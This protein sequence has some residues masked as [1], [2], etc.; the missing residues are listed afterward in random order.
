MQPPIVSKQPSRVP[1]PAEESVDDLL[2]SFEKRWL[3]D[4][5]FLD[6][7][8]LNH[9]LGDD[10]TTLCELVRA[11]LDRKYTAGLEVSLAEYF[12]SYPLLRTN[13]EWV[14]DIC[15]EDFRARTTR[16]LST[17]VDRWM[18]FPEV[19]NTSWWQRLAVDSSRHSRLEIGV[20]TNADGAGEPI[21]GQLFGEFRLVGLLGTGA[22][23]QVYLATQPGLASR[24]VALKVVRRVFDEP[25]HLA[26]LQHTGIVPLYSMHRIGSYTAL[27]MPYCGAA[28]LADWV[29]MEESD[30]SRSGQSLV[31]TIRSAERRITQL[32]SNMVAPS[33][34]L[35]TSESS[36]VADEAGAENVLNQLAPLGPSELPLW[37]AR[38]VAAA[39]AH[40]HLR[41]VVHG[42]LKP[43]N[44]L[45]RNDGEPALIDFNLSQSQG[46]LSNAV[47][48][49]TLPYMSPEQL[50][51][52]LGRGV[53]LSTRSDIFSFGVVM[54]QWIEGRM[55]F[56]VPTSTA[57]T[58]LEIAID[59]LRM[60]LPMRSEYVSPGFRA[61]L[62]KC[63][64]F[65]PSE[66]YADATELEEDLDREVNSRPLKFADEPMLQ[67]RCPKW[68][69]RNAI[70]LRYVAA[71][72]A[73][74]MLW[75]AIGV[76]WQWRERSIRL[77]AKQWVETWKSGIGTELDLLAVP[78][79]RSLTEVVHDIDQRASAITDPTAARAALHPWIAKLGVEEVSS[80]KRQLADHLLVSATLAL[81]Q[82]RVRDPDVLAILKRWL[83]NCEQLQA[84]KQ[85]LLLD[86]LG[87][88]LDGFSSDTISKQPQG[89]A[90]AKWMNRLLE[91]DPEKLPSIER[92]LWAW[93][94]NQMGRTEGVVAC[95]ESIEPMDDSVG[96]YWTVLGD[97]RTLLGEYAS[98]RRAY[99]IAMQRTNGAN[100]IR[101]RNA[102]I[103][104]RMGAWLEAEDE[105]GRVLEAE[106]KNANVLADRARTREKLQRWDDAIEDLDAALE[107]EPSSA[108]LLLM[109]A[110]LLL[111]AGRSQE[112]KLD[113]QRAMQT[114]PTSTADW[115][116][117][118]LVQLPKNPNGALAD[119][120]AAQ[121]LE[122]Y[123]F[124]VLQNLAH[125]L[126]E[127]LNDIDSALEPL[128][129]LLTRRPYNQMARAGRC[130]LYARQRN[131]EACLKDI[132]FLQSAFSRPEPATLYQIACAHAILSDEREQSHDEAIRCLLQAVIRGYGSDLLESDPDL[133]NIRNDSRFQMLLSM[134]QLVHRNPAFT[135]SFNEPP[136]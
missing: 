107:L 57:E 132:D 76:G 45:I 113:Y 81:D 37:F 17:G 133:N 23:S 101:L 35:H 28:T 117:R 96:L 31:R 115:I 6:Q 131:I 25:T 136:Q 44:I 39:L 93:V 56:A 9:R 59:R 77:E 89:Q 3:P 11:D 14:C 123:R 85:S 121:T 22:F 43:A 124:E 5:G 110:R 27:C 120:R 66:R 134:S 18:G 54:Y 13:P 78:S 72:A 119:L 95:L 135:S 2:E 109:R 69:R 94:A 32:R 75:M 16:G 50:R 38:R 60:P 51:M 91:T 87:A 62:Y 8:I 130:V 55:P 61:I 21:L 79:L 99:A 70:G 10:P 48:G 106:G 108:R 4:V 64:S 105:Y 24:F 41:K 20:P 90:F 112:A 92:L 7:F 49:G 40:A 68:L 71:I 114:K 102:A 129:E 19:R 127:H 116:S 86:Q 100:A 65:E 58:D 103:Y 42:D 118:A 46:E 73:M 98:A 74:I 52:L 67:S 84:G 63:L 15:Y 104:E 29:A 30:G 128:Q 82:P 122:P 1:E 111:A 26:R 80:V 47:A 33:E 83:M 53:H 125:V 12:A 126:S 97:A 88:A 34:G 36:E